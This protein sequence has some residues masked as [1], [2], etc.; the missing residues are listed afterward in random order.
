METCHKYCVAFRRACENICEQKVLG[1]SKPRGRKKRRK[2]SDAEKI[3]GVQMPQT[4]GCMS[5]PLDNCGGNSQC[6]V[7]ITPFPFNLEE[8]LSGTAS[9]PFDKYQTRGEE[10]F[11]TS[12]VGSCDC[13]CYPPEVRVML[14][15]LQAQFEAPVRYGYV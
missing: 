8:R 15:D 3:N 1:G 2:R 10:E 4:A 5:S 14:A 9:T 7:P 6:E 13:K 11:S 12:P